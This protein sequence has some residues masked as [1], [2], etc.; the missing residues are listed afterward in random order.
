MYLLF[1]ICQASETV[2]LQLVLLVSVSNGES[3][4]ALP[5]LGACGDE[6]TVKQNPRWLVSMTAE[7]RLFPLHLALHFL[8]PHLPLVNT[9]ALPVLCQGT[10]IVG[11][12]QLEEEVV[13][14]M[15]RA[16]VA[17][18]THDAVLLQVSQH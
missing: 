2:N 13:T 18:A 17:A 12:N 4:E 8:L 6:S 3:A 15:L 9:F 11:E 1:F 10:V 14:E 7:L 16:P 5:N